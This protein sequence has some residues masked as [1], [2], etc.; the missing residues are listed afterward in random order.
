[1]TGGLIQLEFPTVPEHACINQPNFSHDAVS[2]SRTWPCSKRLGQCI[3]IR[4]LRLALGEMIRSFG[5]TA[6]TQQCRSR[7]YP[8]CRHALGSGHS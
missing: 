6:S 7:C 2:S 4:A 8:L 1:M 5:G 3:T